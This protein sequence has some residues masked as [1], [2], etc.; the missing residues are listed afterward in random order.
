MDIHR[1]TIVITRHTIIRAMERGVTPDMIE[2]T[3][4]GGI[5]ERIGKNNFRFIK[6][7]KRKT[8]ICIDEI[9]DTTIVIATVVIKE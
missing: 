6:Q 8:V 7:Y 3:I 1:F 2:A 9:R 4:R 5:I